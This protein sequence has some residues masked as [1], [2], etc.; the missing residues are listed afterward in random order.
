MRRILT[1]LALYLVALTAPLAA[2]TGSSTPDAPPTAA[3]QS[4]ESGAQPATE[5]SGL[6]VRAT[7][8]PTMRAYWHVFAAFAIAW[9]LLFAYAIFL[10]RRFA[11]L[12]REL[13]RL[14]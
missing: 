3:A 1:L 8:P 13:R 14:G 7:P 10:G 5:P 4:A 11:S 6:P 12:E 9:A 2:Q